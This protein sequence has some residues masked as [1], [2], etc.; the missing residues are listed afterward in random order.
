MDSYVESALRKALTLL[1]RPSP[2]QQAI[3]AHL[4]TV[5][6]SI[7]AAA[8]RGDDVGTMLGTLTHVIAL[9]RQ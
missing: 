3:L 6:T 2:D 1:R 5:Q 9:V 8:Q 7:T 4:T